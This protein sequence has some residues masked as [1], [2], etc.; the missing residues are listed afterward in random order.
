TTARASP[1]DELDAI[2]SGTET[3]LRHGTGLGL[4]QLTWA[5]RTMGGEL[6][7]DTD[8]GTT[9]TFTVRDRQ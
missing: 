3:P 7:F 1:D 9:V 8:D 2:D 6:S 5:V 4:W